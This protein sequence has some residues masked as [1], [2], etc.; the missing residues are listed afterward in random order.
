MTSLAT[1]VIAVTATPVWAKAPI[2][3]ESEN[4][5]FYGDVDPVL[6]EERIQKWEVYRK[7][8]YAL[9]GVANPDPD[10]EKLTIYG[11]YDT[12]DLQEFTGNRGIA[13]VY[14]QSVDGPIFLTSI[15]NKYLE[16]GFS[17]QVGFHEYTHHVLNSFVR[18]GFPRWWD[19]G[20]ANYLATMLI[21]ETSVSVGDPTVGHVKSVVENRLSWIDP[22]TVLNAN[23]FYPNYTRREMRKGGPVVFYA[24][25]WLYVHYIRS[26]PKYNG[27]LTEYLTLINTPGMDP[28]DAFEQAFA[29]SVDDFHK[30]AAKY[31]R[32]DD[33]V[34]NRYQPGPNIMKTEMNIEKISEGNLKKAQIPA[35]LSFLND[36]TAS[37][38]LKD[39]N[40]A[41]EDDPSDSR[42]LMGYVSH[43]IYREAYG[44]AVARAEAALAGS[45][46]DT[47]LLHAAAAAR[48]ASVV[49][50]HQEALDDDEY[51]PFPLTDDMKVALARYD[52][53][54]R[55]NPADFFAVNQITT[56]YGNSSE[57]ATDGALDAARMIDQRFMDS[58]N[59]NDGMNLAVIYAKR[60]YEFYACEYYQKSLDSTKDF[61]DRQL[62]NFKARME[63]F[64]TN[65]GSNCEDVDDES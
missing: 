27:Q 45:P 36:D 4:I 65:Y 48:F 21:D 41:Y 19:E 28:L 64:K 23:V 54:Q 59:P 2:K 60:G 18:E 29:V 58:F 62:G 31:F 9:S 17:E 13:G 26:Q 34:V 51:K 8:I 50:P 22:E 40:N 63:W 57:P 46:D 7:M 44:N 32:N 33:F 15:N 61:K 30:E 53:L 42:T 43:D 1:A 20:F 55:K 5:V 56:F 3:I 35:R 37:D 10:Q 52:Q 38:F 16:D 24:Q 6:A 25:S 39:L 47:D 14:T 12:R 11:F 49:G